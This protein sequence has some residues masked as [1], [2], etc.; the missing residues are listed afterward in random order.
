MIIISIFL[1]VFIYQENRDVP[2]ERGIY[3]TEIKEACYLVIMG[4]SFLCKTS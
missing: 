4:D 1:I 3:D 2:A